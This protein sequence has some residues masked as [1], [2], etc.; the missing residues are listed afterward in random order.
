[1]HKRY[2]KANGYVYITEH[3]NHKINEK[4]KD[5]NNI[6]EI[7]IQENRIEFLRNLLPQYPYIQN[8]ERKNDC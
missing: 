4:R 8:G 7:L 2:T 6:K 5:R 1:M 3:G